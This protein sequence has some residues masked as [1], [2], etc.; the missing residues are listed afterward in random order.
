M[1]RFLLLLTLIF[2]YSFV[3]IGCQKKKEE[4]ILGNWQYVYLKNV[5][6]SVL[7]WTFKDDNKIYT[8][9]KTDTISYCDTAEWTLTSKALSTTTLK[10]TGINEWTNGTYEVLTVSKK[11]LII[12]RIILENGSSE[13]AFNRIEF[14]KSK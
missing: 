3:F 14:V 4:K 9:L 6:D 13:G 7:T 1:K 8:E 11:Y 5:G 12:Q 2:S 10:I